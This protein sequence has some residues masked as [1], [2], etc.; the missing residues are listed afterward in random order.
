MQ[1][2]DDRTTTCRVILDSVAGARVEHRRAGADATP[3]IVASAILAGGLLGLEAQLTL[4]PTGP[5]GNGIPVPATLA[6]AIEAFEGSPRVKRMLA[7]WFIEAFAATRR[8]ELTQYEAW[9]RENI[10]AFELGRHLEHQ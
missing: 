1:G 9:L 4:P 6:E 3:Y 10:T 7:D 8:R 2:F 5:S